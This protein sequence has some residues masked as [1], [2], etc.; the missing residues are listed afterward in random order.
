[1]RSNPTNI[2][3]V[4]QPRLV[5]FVSVIYLSGFDLRQKTHRHVVEIGLIV[6]PNLRTGPDSSMKAISPAHARPWFLGTA[7]PTQYIYQQMQNFWD[8]M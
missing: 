1:M 2:T 4:E 6:R 3:G 7:K 5:R 8:E